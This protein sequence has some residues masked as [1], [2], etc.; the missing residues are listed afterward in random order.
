MNATAPILMLLR[1]LPL[2]DLD[3]VRDEVDRLIS[4]AS[5]SRPIKEMSDAD[6]MAARENRP[7]L[8]HIAATPGASVFDMLKLKDTGS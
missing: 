6:F 5:G 4:S 2:E 1:S 7:M 8:R 3:T